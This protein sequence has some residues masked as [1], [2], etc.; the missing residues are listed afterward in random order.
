MEWFRE[1][2]YEVVV[3]QLRQGLAKCY[4]IAFENRDSVMEAKITPHIL[5]FIN[6][7]LSTFGIGVE[8]N[9]ISASTTFDSA[10]S[11]SLARTAE[12]TYQDPVFK[13]IKQEFAKDFNF[14]NSNTMRLHTL[15]YKLKK[16][17]K[18]LENRFKMLIQSFLIEEKCRYLSSFT[19]KT[20]ELELPGEFLLPKHT[21][22]YVRINRFMPRVDIVQKY[23]T[24]ARRLYIRGHNGKIYP[25]L[26]VNDSGLVDARREERVLQL[27]RMLNHYLGKQKVSI[28]CIVCSV[29]ECRD[30]IARCFQ[31]TARRFLHFM[32]PR[33]VAVSLQKRLVEDNPASISLLDIFKKGCKKLAIEHDA[34]IHYYY[35]RL[36]AVQTRGIK[37]SH[38]VYRDILKGV[39][40]MMVPK[41]V[42]K[43]WALTTFPSATDYWQF[44]KMVTIIISLFFI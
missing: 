17:I 8:N 40:T 33:V 39:Q 23:N 1:H 27:L 7:V 2:W 41:K 44:R 10:A 32:V 3:R 15:I 35:E 30:V 24:A 4:A 6:K 18:I 43:N 34:P 5:N 22:Y 29:C 11:E 25:Y 38:Q 13:E 37:A 31:E 9:S 26:L 19:L 21:H 36:A 12:A 42:L 20:A 16:W 14:S 28:E